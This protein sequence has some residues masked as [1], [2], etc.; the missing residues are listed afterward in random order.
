MGIFSSKKITY[1]DS[2]AY[3]MS[4][5]YPERMNY[6]KTITIG[7]ALGYGH[8]PFI[9]ESITHGLMEGPY[10]GQ[11]NVLRW[12]K[13][14]YTEGI[15]T[16]TLGGS[17][18]LN[19]APVQQ[20]METI[21]LGPV[22]IDDAWVGQASA[23]E[24]ARQYIYQQYP[25]EWEELE[26]T[27]N[28]FSANP[29]TVTVDIVS[30]GVFNV[31]MVGYNDQDSFAYITYRDVTDWIGDP[32]PAPNSLTIVPDTDGIFIGYRSSDLGSI[33]QELFDDYDVDSVLFNSTNFNLVIVVDGPVTQMSSYSVT[34][35]SDNY[36]PLVDYSILTGKTT[37]TYVIPSL[38]LTN[39][40][41]FTFT[42]TQTG[43]NPAP[44]YEEYSTPKMYI[45]RYGS[46]DPI[47]EPTRPPE[48]VISG[49]FM[50]FVPIRIENK[51]ISEAP[52][53]E[54]YYDKAKKF[55]KRISGGK[56][57][58]K[59]IDQINDNESIDDIDFA[60]MVFGVALNTKS[61]YCKQ[62]LYEFIT[63]LMNEQVYTKTDFDYWEQQVD[64]AKIA[65]DDV[66]AAYQRFNSWETYDVKTALAIYEAID[67]PVLSYNTISQKSEWLPN[68]YQIFLHWCYCEQSNVDP[69]PHAS[70]KVGD[71]WL[72]AGE[73]KEVTRL[74]VTKERTGGRGDYMMKATEETD[75]FDT[76][77]IYR[78][79]SESS[80]TKIYVVG[81]QQEN[82]VYNG[83]AIWIGAIEALEDEEE[84][85]L[86]CPIHMETFKRL[87]AKAR[88]QVSVE[89]NYMI[90]N[91]YKI[92]KQRWYERGIFK[93]VFAI[94]I[95][96]ASVFFAPAGT[97]GIGL[98]GSNVA[99]GAAMGFTAGT[100]TAAIAGAVVNAIAG[101][102]VSQLFSVVAGSLFKGKLGAILG[103]LVMFFGGMLANSFLSTGSFNINWNDIFSP[104]NILNLTSSVTKAATAW[105]Q[106]DIA[107]IAETMEAEA[108][109]YKA[110]SK[111]IQDLMRD[112]YGMDGRGFLDPLM[113][114]GRSVIH[115]ES[116]ETF[117][118][119]TLLTG[120]EIAEL[121][122]E[123]VNGFAETNLQL[124]LAYT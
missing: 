53:K 117:L 95:A 22:R 29:P 52:Y 105:Y 60:F 35:D 115:N 11:R 116:S 58:D 43:P 47:M 56:K 88:N 19:P 78:K 108:E 62:Y 34:Y 44:E 99:V 39:G 73:K 61:R 7:G 96:I 114:I 94:V 111:H 76:F 63:T 69:L 109:K 26:W 21:R 103:T 85:S 12:A 89:N 28:L 72:E 80:V 59:L 87:S 112:M 100:I 37:I 33:T 40:D 119:R 50:P 51:F 71:V 64:A 92:V 82:I 9:G 2:V 17:G 49:R 70:K 24:W 121:S 46:G 45:Y 122:L 31:P 8:S 16:I 38:D 23:E 102:I 120:S 93:V 118:D 104:K 124:P 90:F 6:M 55:Y 74:I 27:Y 67:V 54:V 18:N 113:L 83:Q 101:M 79:N 36:S 25:D 3:N 75:E 57:I 106:V 98:L 91:C 5:D 84:S 86:L 110:E 66:M 68:L 30:K 48:T 123:M 10:S 1:V 107:N 65:Y 20:F 41:P 81:F 42:F 15:P 13:T 77:T 4:G 14:H 97:F 32:P